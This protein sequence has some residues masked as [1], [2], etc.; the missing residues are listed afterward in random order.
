MNSM[1][2]LYY[3]DKKLKQIKKKRTQKTKR[4]WGWILTALGALELPS[5]LSSIAAGSLSGLGG[6]LIFLIPGIIL[7]LLAKR[8]VDRW[9]RYEAII[10][11]RG[12]TPI[13]LIA[14]KM[15]L[16]EKTV[17][18]DLQEMIHSDFFIGPNY[19]IEA[20]IDAERDL[21]VM[22]SGGEPLKP[23]PDL[24]TQEEM[25]AQKEEW[26][27]AAETASAKADDYMDA[28]YAG[29]ELT[30]LEM[31]QKAIT[32]TKD[33][34]VR[35]YLYGL[36]GSLRRIDERLQDHPDLKEKMSIKRLY[37][38]YLPQIMELIRKYQAPDTP[39]ELKK[40]IR[41][42][43]QTSAAALANIEA[44][45]LER[46]QMNAE[47][48]IEVLKNMFAQDGLLGRDGHQAAGTKAGQTAAAGSG[49]QAAAEARPQPQAQGR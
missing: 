12:N 30:D 16:P 11:N 46:D 28:E 34:E 37:K 48:D 31:I 23:L 19:N 39:P 1:N 4:V 44:D 38:Y 14:K 15:K 6:M 2:N 32:E 33:D 41:E 7:L 3:N 42:A 47:V 17:Y 13:S 27:S 25:A 45:M 43:L 29:V 10:D 35:G 24:P 5:V 20:Y 21:L 26:T 40:Q 8:Q 49:A 22:C 9:D 36:E 18:S